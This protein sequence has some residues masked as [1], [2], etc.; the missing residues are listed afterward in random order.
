MKT[1]IIVFVILSFGRV[2][3]A[4][5][6]Q[7]IQYGSNDGK[8][9]SIYNTEVYYEEYGKG[10]PL[11]MI[12]GGTVS[13]YSF[14]KVIPDLSKKFRVIAVDTPGHGRSQQSDTL[15]YQ[16][17][18]NYFS[19]LIDILKLDSVYIIGSSD[20]GVVAQLLAADR[21]DKIKRAI[22]A[23]AQF[24]YRGF[25]KSGEQLV[26]NLSPEVVEKDWG[27]WVK[28]YQS[29]AY[30]GNDWRD[31]VLDV[32]KMWSEKVYVPIEKVKKIKS[33]FLIVLGDRDLITI[34]HGI[35]MY[36][37]ITGGEF[38]VLPNTS[39]DVFNEQPELVNK[40]AIE[41]LTKK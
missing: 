33:R 7:S 15:S 34:E 22:S 4:L 39:H 25:T 36:N 26:D 14:R 38:L 1:V 9:V 35:E 6:Q 23:G 20:G 10:I 18:T 12:H 37:S 30:D 24:G 16:L 21:P 32:K 8:Y 13:L 5:G 2:N 41:F 31:F 27:S 17:I 11:L 3:L 28:N 29:A 40:I 19:K